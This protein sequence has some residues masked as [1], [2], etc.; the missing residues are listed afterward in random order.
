M[1]YFV[2]PEEMTDLGDLLALFFFTFN[3]FPF[4]SRLIESRRSPNGL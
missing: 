3:A 4:P 2:V 1:A